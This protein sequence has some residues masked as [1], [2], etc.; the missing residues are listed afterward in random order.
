M[1]PW[2]CCLVSSRAFH[3]ARAATR[4]GIRAYELTS[5][6]SNLCSGQQEDR[7]S[8]FGPMVSAKLVRKKL[9]WVAMPL[10]L[11]SWPGRDP[12]RRSAI[13][14][15]RT[16]REFGF[17]ETSWR[18]PRGWALISCTNPRHC[19]EFRDSRANEPRQPANPRRPTVPCLAYGRDPSS[20]LA[21]DD[22]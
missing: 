22:V 8:G 6:V 17:C 14:L 9:R 3:S 2:P 18:V 11:L 12:A 1:E 5:T 19:R 15:W 7:W 16:T 4:N 20:R 21:T 10:R 13:P